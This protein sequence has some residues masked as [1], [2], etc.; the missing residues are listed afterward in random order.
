ME[1]KYIGSEEFWSL[2]KE[3]LVFSLYFAALVLIL[4]LVYLFFKEK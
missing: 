1:F 4:R 3:N 2:W